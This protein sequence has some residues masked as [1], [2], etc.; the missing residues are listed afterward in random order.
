MDSYQ[1]DVDKSLIVICDVCLILS[2][3]NSM[4]RKCT[5]QHLCSL[6]ERVGAARSLSGAKDLTDRLL[7]AVSKLSQDSSQEAR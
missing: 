4:V 1:G 2:H 3:L 6:V 5:A 7:P